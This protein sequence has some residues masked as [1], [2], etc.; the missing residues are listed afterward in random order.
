MEAV[1]GKFLS[2]IGTFDDVDAVFFPGGRHFQGKTAVVDLHI[3]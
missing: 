3:G 1:G 2:L